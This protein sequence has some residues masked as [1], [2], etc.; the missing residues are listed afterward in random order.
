MKKFDFVLQFA[1]FF[2]IFLGYNDIIRINEKLFTPLNKLKYLHL[3]LNVCID[4]NARCRSQVVALRQKV[5]EQCSFD[6]PEVIETTTEQPATIVTKLETELNAF[7]EEIQEL[8]AQLKTA[9]TENSNANKPA[10]D[11]ET[12]KKALT[13]KSQQIVK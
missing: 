4:E 3:Y 13:A 9:Q 8:K 2:S 7:K 1:R 6:E 5:E 11:L 10:F 12:F